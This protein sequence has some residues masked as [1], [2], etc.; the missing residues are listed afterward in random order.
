MNK[1]FFRTY[2]TPLIFVMLILLVGGV[3]AF[4]QI[5]VSL[6][7]PATFPKVKIIAENNEQ[8]VDK[9]MITVTRPLE[10][11]IKKIPALSG[12][13]SITSRGSCEISAFLD[14]N[15]DIY[16]SQ[17]LIESRIA[18]IKNDLPADTRITVERMDPSILSVMGFSLESK[19]KNLMELKLLADYT[20]KPYLSQVQGVSDV[21]VQG[22]KVKEY[23]IS[24][25]PDKLLQYRLSA[26][27]VSDAVAKTGFISSNGFMNSYR[28]LYLNLTDAGVYSMD[29]IENIPVSMGT[30]TPVF[31]KD[32]ARVS[33][34]E[35]VEYIKINANGHEGVLINIL[36]QPDANLIDVTEATRQKISELKQLLP[37][38]V[39]VN[40]YYIQADFVNTSI[41]SIRDALLIGLLLAI[42]VAILFL[43]SG[44]ASI[45]ILV[46]IPVTL[47][48][49]LLVMHNLGYTLNIMTI[50]G[51]AAAIGLVID[52]AVVV[53]EQLHRTREEHP[54]TP[55]FQLVQQ[56]MNYLFPSLIGSSL[57][58][59]VI[60]IPFS[61]M[62]GVA[63]AYFRILAYTMVIT[64]AS[65]FLVSSL[66]LP[67]LYGWL[68]DI[69]PKRVKPILHNETRR[70]INYLVHRPVISL[71]LI[72]ILVAASVVIFPRLETGF[73]P[74]MDEG[75]IVMDYNSP[76]GTSIEETNNILTRVDSMILQIPEVVAYSRRT[77]AQ[78]G[79]FITEPNRG[80]YLI[81]LNKDRQRS[82]N[83][84][85][86]AIRHRVESEVPNLTIDFGQVVGDML[87]DLITSVQPINLKVFGPDREKLQTYAAQISSLLEKIPGT[88]DVFDGVVIAGPNITVHP[89]FAKMAVYGISPSD[90]Q[91]QLQTAMQGVVVGAV[92]D[93]QQMTDIRMIYDGGTDLREGE[94]RR[95]KILLADGKFVPLETIATI[96]IQSGVAEQERENLQPI[97][98]ITSRLEGRDLGSVMQEIKASVATNIAFEKGY[99]VLYGGA[100]AQQQQSFRELLS[101]LIL[102][103]L[104]VLLVQMILFR[105]LPVALA[106]LFV[107]L[108]GI[109]G[110]VTGLYLTHT[111]LNVGSYMGMIMI[112]GIIAENA[113]FTYQQY[114]TARQKNSRD[115]ALNYA[116]A[117]RLRPKLMTALGAIIAL[118]PLALGIGTGAQLHQP[119]AVAVIG[120]LI[121]ALPLL[122][123][124][125]PAIIRML[126]QPPPPV[127]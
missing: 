28:R 101:I 119:L 31:I 44:Q 69:L 93:P 114:S 64:L 90:L 71:L 56:S 42:V 45:A 24:L 67:A 126:N 7:P 96:T 117:A 27:A 105:N 16:T 52:D 58:T 3:Y 12:I 78:M 85:I 95:M 73:L 112:V 75:E 81:E 121:A 57:S 104:M 53:I 76:P 102:A 60:F 84:V 14:W 111:P 113:I 107:S 87:G 6:F 20:I 46:T 83:E 88:A 21:Q 125:F 43:H 33:I 115:D 91:Y 11:A 109:G 40:P 34:E 17:Q 1:L 51:L 92:I 63:G 80:D 86:A 26:Q 36:K 19:D 127:K 108:L 47:S 106:I 120:G 49:A 38:G 122:L 94:L 68:V 22:G 70:W 50:G 66:M 48:A 32:I 89:D 97:V 30:N 116:L 25:D 123:V 15:T 2:R 55:V 54:E 118:M 35:K 79:F 8:P 18:A 5:H 100:Y 61:L 29:E 98:G 72:A 41:I 13:N 23:R 10:E 74:E 77:G 4:L 37:V 39:T 103:S 65:S 59:M 110:A 124:V 99:G 82:T 9:M 62:T